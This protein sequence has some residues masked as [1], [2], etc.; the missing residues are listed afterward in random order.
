M[1]QEWSGEAGRRGHDRGYDAP[2]RNA[3]R[4]FGADVVA[5]R[6][7]RIPRTHTMAGD[8]Q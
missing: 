4:D 6:R 7:A 8:P 2:H 5:G 3:H 1:R